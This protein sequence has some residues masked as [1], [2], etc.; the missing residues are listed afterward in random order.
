M[1]QQKLY[2]LDC[3]G[4]RKY[5]GLT[6]DLDARWAAHSTGRGA[7]WTKRYPPICISSEQE[8]PEE[9]AQQEEQRVT[10]ELMLRHGVNKVRGANLSSRYCYEQTDKPII[11]G[12]VRKALDLDY[13][14]A[15][16]LVEDMFEAD[17]AEKERERPGYHSD[18]FGDMDALAEI[19]G[20]MGIGE[21][22]Y[23]EGDIY[24]H[25]D[26]ES[27]GGGTQDGECGEP[28]FL[29]DDRFSRDG[30]FPEWELLG[31]G[32]VS[33]DVAHSS[34]GAHVSED[35]QYVHDDG[36]PGEEGSS[37]GDSFPGGSS[38]DDSLGIGAL[39]EG[40]GIPNDYVFPESGDSPDDD[41]FPVDVVGSDGGASSE[42]D[43]VQK[44]GA[45]PGFEGCEEGYEYETHEGVIEHEEKH[46]HEE[47][48][49]D[50]GTG[51]GDQNFSRHGG[52]DDENG[53]GDGG[54]PPVEGNDSDHGTAPEEAPVSDDDGYSSDGSSGS[55]DDPYDGQFSDLDQYSDDV[56]YSD[57]GY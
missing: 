9:T 40:E 4:G 47:Y 35:E 33:D 44:V 2:V 3:A 30:D 25:V 36:F 31:D 19:T 56:T 18:E 5:V 1:S 8:V 46:V 54:V 21:G 37:S 11:A 10:A 27:D 43:V 28:D 24:E 14:H 50:D 57:D 52:S 13:D 16:R 32:N 26:G 6:R 38:D 15:R 12:T 41:G 49:Y 17:R 39:S 53:H 55:G 48:H 20:R 34:D 22:P 45:D 7:E 42:E 23:R 51:E 29:D